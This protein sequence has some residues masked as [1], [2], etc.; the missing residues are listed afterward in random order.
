MCKSELRLY[1]STEESDKGEEKRKRTSASLIRPEETAE[2]RRCSGR[3]RCTVGWNSGT[4][5]CT[6]GEIYEKDG[7]QRG[8]QWAEA[9]QTMKC[10]A[11]HSERKLLK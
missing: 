7:M 1:V 6:V 4:E 3:E 5:R 2:Q 9:A 11:M 10:G 8:A